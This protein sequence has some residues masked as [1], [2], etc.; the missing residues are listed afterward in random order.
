MATSLL[1]DLKWAKAADSP[2]FVALAFLSGVEYRNSDFNGFICDDLY[3]TWRKNFVNFGSVGLNPKFKNGK[4]VLPLI[5]Q[6]LVSSCKA[7]L[8]L[9][10]IGLLLSGRR[11]LQ[12]DQRR[13]QGAGTR[14]QFWMGQRCI[15]PHV[16]QAKYL[17]IFR[18]CFE[19]WAA[20]G[21]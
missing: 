20:P 6:Q 11:M 14:R 16:W 12:N 1:L 2:S 9:Q 10:S 5:Y 17:H 18:L 7:H 3:A 15:C 21:I 19:A 13:T 4:H 8:M